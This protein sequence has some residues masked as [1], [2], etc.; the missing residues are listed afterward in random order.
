[1]ESEKSEC[2]I[3]EIKDSSIRFC[4]LRSYIRVPPTKLASSMPGRFD[5]FGCGYG[6]PS[7]IF[8]KYRISNK[9]R[10]LHDVHIC[11]SEENC[12]AF[13]LFPSQ[14]HQTD[15]EKSDCE[16]LKITMSS[17]RFCVHGSQSTVP[18][19]KLGHRSLV[20]RPPSRHK[21]HR[22]LPRAAILS[23]EFWC[24]RDFS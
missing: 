17:C 8:G 19:A 5:D 6:A 22:P 24:D 20:D 16:K 9:K 4:Q 13:P 12:D 3:V 1:M 14:S 7:V 15:S 10:S 18:P 23:H 11:P 2:F 21:F